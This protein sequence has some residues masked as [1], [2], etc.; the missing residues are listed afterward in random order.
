MSL[1][2]LQVTQHQKS[3]EKSEPSYLTALI[4]AYPAAIAS[5][6]GDSIDD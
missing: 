1:L 3:R 4:V 2:F 6:I 5:D